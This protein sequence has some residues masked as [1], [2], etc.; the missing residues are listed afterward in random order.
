MTRGNFYTV[1]LEYGGGTY[2]TQVSGGS[3]SAALSK[4]EPGIPSQELAKG[5]MTLET[6]IA[7]ARSSDLIPVDDCRGVWCTSFS[8]K[9]GLSLINVVVTDVSAAISV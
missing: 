1:I 6:L 4:W 5:K 9:V 2:I 7:K 3:P 8:T